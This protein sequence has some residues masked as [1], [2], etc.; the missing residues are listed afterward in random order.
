MRDMSCTEQTRGE[1][2]A[3]HHVIQ[4]LSLGLLLQML[5]LSNLKLLAVG[6]RDHLSLSLFFSFCVCLLCCFFKKSEIFGKNTGGGERCHEVR[7]Q[8]K[9][10]H[11]DAL[12]AQEFS[13]GCTV[14]H[15]GAFYW[16][17]QR[18]LCSPMAFLPALWGGRRLHPKRTALRAFATTGL[19]PK[20]RSIQTLQCPIP[21]P[22]SVSLPPGA[23]WDT[24]ASKCHQ[25]VF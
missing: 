20:Y 2:G 18:S 3:W 14:E 6:K 13:E 8:T 10:S 12:A 24:L 23:R 19:S 17:L 7:G 5:C 22:H 21:Q 16:W 25:R 4:V 9:S 1:F 15:A 11:E